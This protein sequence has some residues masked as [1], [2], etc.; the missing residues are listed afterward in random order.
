MSS[1]L[2]HFLDNIF[3]NTRQALFVIIRIEKP[4]ACGYARKERVAILRDEAGPDNLLVDDA[5][6]PPIYAPRIFKSGARN[7]LG[8]NLFEATIH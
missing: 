2:L 4:F 3:F 8:A 7:R 6:A 1:Y 5:F